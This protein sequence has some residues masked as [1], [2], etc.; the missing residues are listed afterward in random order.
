MILIKYYVTA[1]LTELR[2][3]SSQQSQNNFTPFKSSIKIY[4]ISGSSGIGFLNKKKRLLA[5]TLDRDLKIIRVVLDSV[6]RALE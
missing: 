1:T 4:T 5:C 6:V 2:V 3:I